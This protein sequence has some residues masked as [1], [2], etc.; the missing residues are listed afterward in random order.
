M[1]SKK[2]ISIFLLLIIL[3]SITGCG[4]MQA[5]K[6]MITSEED[7][8]DT[9]EKPTDSVEIT[10]EQEDARD[11]VIYY[12]SDKNLLV[13]IKRKISW[14]TGIA[15]KTLS[16]MVNNDKN[17][18]DMVKSGLNPV[19][20]TGSEVIGM[21][22]DEE[23]GLAKVNFSKEILN[24]ND[25]VEEVSLV[26]A[27]VYTLTEFP[28]INKVQFMIDGGIKETLTYGTDVFDP[29]ER[30]DINLVDN[31]GD[32][33]VVVYYKGTTNGEYEYYVPV[34]KTVTAPSPDMYTAL[35]E[36]FEGPPESSGLYTDIP[37]GV[38]LKGV[39]VKDGVAVVDLSGDTKENIMN[40]QAFDS[41]NKNIAL[42][43]SQFDEIE[44]VEM[45]ID[46]KTL[47]EAKMN[48]STPESI[49]TFANEY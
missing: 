2:L 36:L 21:S 39:E 10:V 46:G 31:N 35:E 20:P 18:T 12:K 29:I 34:T 9:A 33:K 13:P 44:K 40:Q 43:L 15:K 8:K 5:M 23:T 37:M 17:Q 6:E 11:T 3:V 27:V 30:R 7:Q 22:V 45:L 41:M 42:T 19:L 49:P 26:N 4:K 14:D 25:K 32:S 38:E 24:T 48:L 16:Y 1:V 28:T 47:E